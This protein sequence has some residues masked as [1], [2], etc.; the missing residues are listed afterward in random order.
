MHLFERPYRGRSHSGWPTCG[1]IQCST[2]RATRRHTY[3]RA[4][5]RGEDVVRVT[6]VVASGPRLHHTGLARAR[7]APSRAP[8]SRRAGG[9]T[10]RPHRA[11]LWRGAP[12]PPTPSATTATR[13]G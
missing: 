13:R 12:L 3:N 6:P 5:A 4:P 7:R 11:A 10:G 9:P 8:S 2:V 1:V